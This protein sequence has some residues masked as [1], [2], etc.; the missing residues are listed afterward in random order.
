LRFSKFFFPFLS[1]FFAHNA[2]HLTS[3]MLRM[4]ERHFLNDIDPDL[5]GEEGEVLAFLV[6]EAVEMLEVRN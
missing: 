3:T 2:P 1:F 6:K 4:K 5:L